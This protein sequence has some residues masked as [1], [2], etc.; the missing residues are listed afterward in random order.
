[1]RNEKAVCK[2]ATQQLTVRHATVEVRTK[3]ER[4]K[5]ILIRKCGKQYAKFGDT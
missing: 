5:T 4:H 3:I 2:M 1:M